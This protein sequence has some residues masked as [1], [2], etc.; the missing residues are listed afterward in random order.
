MTVEC[1]PEVAATLTFF[2][3]TE[4]SSLYT[5]SVAFGVY[6][7]F[8]RAKAVSVILA[9]VFTNVKRPSSFPFVIAEL[10][11]GKRKKSI[12]WPS[13]CS[14][15]RIAAFESLFITRPS[16]S[17]VKRA[18]PI[19]PR[20]ITLRV[21][22]KTNDERKRVSMRRIIVLIIRVRFAEGNGIARRN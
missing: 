8:R 18:R 4:P 20:E 12:S 22:D 5:S 7:I 19:A 11:K 1:N 3:I 21:G 6:H 14:D 15:R 9:S 2:T 17:G 16:L 10:D 13:P